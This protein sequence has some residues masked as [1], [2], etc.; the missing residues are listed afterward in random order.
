MTNPNIWQAPLYFPLSGV[1][2]GSS[3]DVARLGYF[4]LPVV[5]SSRGAYVLYEGYNGLVN[6]M[7]NYSRYS[8]FSVRCV[9]R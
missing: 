7:T 3:Y 6:P 4:W 2:S 8:G 5:Y 9:S 1:W